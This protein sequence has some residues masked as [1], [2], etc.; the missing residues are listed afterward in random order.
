[1]VKIG[2][3]ALINHVDIDS[4]FMAFKGADILT[5]ADPYFIGIGR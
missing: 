4:N 3:I 2:C 1:M 5:G